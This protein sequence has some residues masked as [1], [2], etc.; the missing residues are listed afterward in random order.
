M[1]VDLFDSFVVRCDLS[2]LLVKPESRGFDDLSMNND[3]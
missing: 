1:D 2:G 3:P